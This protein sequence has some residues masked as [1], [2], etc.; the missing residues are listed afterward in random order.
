[1]NVR[2]EVSRPFN[3]AARYVIGSEAHAKSDRPQEPSRPPDPPPNELPPYHAEYAEKAH[4]PIRVSQDRKPDRELKHDR[5][6][7]LPVSKSKAP[8]QH[9]TTTHQDQCGKQ[10]KITGDKSSEAHTLESVVDSHSQGL[11]GQQWSDRHQLQQHSDPQEDDHEGCHAAHIRQCH[12]QL[13]D[14]ARRAS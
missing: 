8:C 2:L 9:C 1:V 11:A 14:R 3:V 13:L 7:V 12:T 4:K 10:P 5:R 6:S